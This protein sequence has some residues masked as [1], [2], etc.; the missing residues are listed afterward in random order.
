[1]DHGKDEGPYMLRARAGA[2]ATRGS[3]MLTLLLGRELELCGETGGDGVTGVKVEASHWGL[4][5]PSHSVIYIRTLFGL[6]LY[7]RKSHQATRALEGVRHAW[8]V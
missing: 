8:T 1:M 4:L 7:L 3:V 6:A 2:F 5:A